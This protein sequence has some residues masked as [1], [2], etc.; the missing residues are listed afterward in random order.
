[1]SETVNQD[2]WPKESLSRDL[3]KAYKH[4]PAVPKVDVAKNC[5]ANVPD[6]PS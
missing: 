2:Y 1:M 3:T 6:S 4:A 5:I